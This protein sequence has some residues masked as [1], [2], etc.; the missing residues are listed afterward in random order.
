ME[1]VGYGKWA[2]WMV[3][4]MLLSLLPDNVIAQPGFVSVDCGGKEN[5]TDENNITWVTDANYIDVG[6][7]EVTGIATSPSYLQSLRFFPKPL[8]KSCYRLLVV[9][10]VPHLL[11]LS[12]A[13]GNYSRFSAS[14]PVFTFTIETSGFLI[15][16]QLSRSVD[17]YPIIHEGIY[18]SSGRE[19]Y[20]CLIRK[21]NSDDPFINAIELRALQKWH[22]WPG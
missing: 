14:Y 1:K 10:N 6:E 11:R 15:F 21:Y 2:I 13:L 3:I 4:T 17:P 19:L 22:V 18:V 16:T 12:F 5:Y 8:N 9:P 7:T 20:I